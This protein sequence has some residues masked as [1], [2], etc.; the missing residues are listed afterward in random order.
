[1]PFR[2]P[3]G[4]LSLCVLPV[5]LWTASCARSG[6]DSR[7][8]TADMPLH[9]E[10]H[11]EAARIEGSALPTTMP[12]TVEW[13]FDRPQPGWKAA[14][15]ANRAYNTVQLT[16][17]REALRVTLAEGKRLGSNDLPGFFYVDVSDWRPDDWALV[18]V[19][20]RAT[21]TAGRLTIGF[22]LRE[23]RGVAAAAPNPFEGLGDAVPLVSDGAIHAYQF[24]ADNWRRRT[25]D[26]VSWGQFGFRLVAPEPSSI[27]ILSIGVVPKMAVYASE[28]LGF[29]TLPL[30]GGS[31]RGVFVHA[32]ARIDFQVAV[33]DGGQLEVGLGV[34]RGASAEFRVAAR[35]PGT[36][37]K[38]LL[39]ESWSNPD[40]WADRVVNLKEFAGK[41]ITL[42]LQAD[43]ATPATVAFWSTPTVSGS[44]RTSKPNVILYVIDGAGADYM[45]VYGYSRRTTPNLERLAAEGAV[46][47]RVYSS[48]QWTKPSNAS[49]MTSLHNSVLG[50][51]SGAPDPV[52]AEAIT[53]AEHFHQVGYR[54][55]VFTSNPNAASVSGLERGADVT[56]DTASTN[57]STSSVALHEDFWRW[58][59][60]YQGL[61]YWVHFQ[62]TDVHRPFNPDPAFAG[63][64]LSPE[65]RARLLQWG[66]Q[67][68]AAGGWDV[69]DA[70]FKTT[71]I[72]RHAFYQLVQGMYDQSLA[73]NDYQLGRL[74]DR[75]KATGEWDNTL[76]IV[77]ADHSINNATDIDMAAGMLAAPPPAWAL[78]TPM[79]RPSISRVPLIV[80]WPARIAGG[81]R[82]APAVSLI[83]LLPTVLDLAGLPKADVSQGRSLAPLLRGERGWTPQPVILDMFERNPETRELEGRLE[84]VD[85]RW[86]A[87]M[88]IGPPDRDPTR[89]RPWPLLLFDLWNDPICI[90]PVNDEHPDLVKKYTKFLEDTWKD[91]QLLAKRFKPGAKTALTPEQLERLRSLGYIR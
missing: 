60:A 70:G 59:E 33:P 55:A 64:F 69:F 89:R 48:S 10:D 9:L 38:T 77:T 23:T 45:S 15:P 51:V 29:R 36:D 84:V 35:V 19:R 37:I 62:P 4:R 67:L 24:R 25:T 85:G 54:T 63:L 75:L 31:R 68:V 73:H 8:L 79:F 44:A 26:D 80:S 6:E 57:T 21:N 61:P 50:N 47:E 27:D 53:M 49:F 32:P 66:E 14:A 71:G 90:V 74:I 40:Q 18:V 72:D 78:E 20:A 65:Q 16:Q 46:F 5:I 1:M 56:R 42:T 41:T 87:S 3:S 83:D 2:C 13:L 34:M 43:A 30:A 7:V 88:L 17:T 52:P 11:L 28:R 39:H 82:F 76:L 12:A 81:L 86:G 58:R 22:N 91:H